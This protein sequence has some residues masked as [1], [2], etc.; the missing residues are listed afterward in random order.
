MHSTRPLVALQGLVPGRRKH[1]WAQGAGAY[2]MVAMQIRDV[3]F[4]VM[5]ATTVEEQFAPARKLGALHPLVAR[6]SDTQLEPVAEPTRRDRANQRVVPLLRTS[7]KAQTRR[8]RRRCTE[9]PST[10]PARFVE[11]PTTKSGPN[12]GGTDTTAK[13]LFFFASRLWGNVCNMTS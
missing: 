4:Q 3:A 10:S 1:R 9:R 5:T 13:V 8:N 11:R 12:L 6:I 7:T 2:G